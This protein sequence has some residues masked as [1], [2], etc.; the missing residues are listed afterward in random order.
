[1]PPAAF[2]PRSHVEVLRSVFDIPGTGLTPALAES[3][4]KLDFPDRDA[5]RIDELSIKANEGT[6]SDEERTQLQAY[7]NIGDLRAYWQSKARQALSHA[8]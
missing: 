1:M 3:I 6:L 8:E 2:H 5:A 4:L 7:V